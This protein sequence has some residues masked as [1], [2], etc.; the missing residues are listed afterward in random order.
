MLYRKLLLVKF[1]LYPMIAFLIAIHERIFHWLFWLGFWSTIHFSVPPTRHLKL[2]SL[3]GA[4]S[5][6]VFIYEYFIA[7]NYLHKVNDGNANTR[8]EICSK[9]II[10]T[11][12][13]HLWRNSF[14]IFKCLHKEH[15]NIH[16]T[17]YILKCL[18]KN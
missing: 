15:K 7:N 3:Y 1:C 8:C 14:F 10:K 4:W 2:E 5:N 17:R 9:P 6:I 13:Q 18:G 11:L 12:E 16:H